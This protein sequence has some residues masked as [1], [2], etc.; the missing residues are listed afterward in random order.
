M[1]AENL[2][3]YEKDAGSGKKII[4]YVE[5]LDGKRITYRTLKLQG[6]YI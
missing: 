2:T 6:M 4:Y 3:M 5:G 1:P